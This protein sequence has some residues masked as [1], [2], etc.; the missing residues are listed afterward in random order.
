M[1]ENSRILLLLSHFTQSKWISHILSLSP[2][3]L[4]PNLSFMKMHL[5]T[6]RYSMPL[7]LSVQWWMHN[8]VVRFSTS[9]STVNE[10]AKCGESLIRMW[11]ASIESCSLQCPNT[12]LGLNMCKLPSAKIHTWRSNN[13]RHYLYLLFWAG[14]VY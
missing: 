13:K 7:Y 4:I 2:G 11:I 6:R 10:P 1:A 5:I 8:E 14:A 12:Y 9:N 3:N